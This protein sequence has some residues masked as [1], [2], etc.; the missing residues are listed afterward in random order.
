MNDQ[1]RKWVEDIRRIIACGPFVN[2]PQLL[3]LIDAQDAVVKALET[4]DVLTVAQKMR[5]RGHLIVADVLE[6]VDAARRALAE[7]KLE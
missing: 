7:L 1:W 5:E 6:G 4:V 2:T 3:R